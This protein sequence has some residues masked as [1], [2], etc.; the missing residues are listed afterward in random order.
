MSDQKKHRVVYVIYL[1]ISLESLIHFLDFQ[2]L[3]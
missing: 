2:L 3:H 1:G